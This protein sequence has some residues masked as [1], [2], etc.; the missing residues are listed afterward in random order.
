MFKP[1][2]HR[3]LCMYLW[4]PPVTGKTM[5]RIPLI[6]VF[7]DMVGNFT[8]DGKFSLAMLPDKLLAVLDEIDIWSDSDLALDLTKQ[9]LEGTEFTVARKNRD[10]GVVQPIHTFITTNTEPPTAVN[11][12]KHRSYHIE[13]VLSRIHP[14]ETRDLDTLDEGIARTVAKDEAPAWA[15]LCTQ[16]QPYITVPPE[17]LPPS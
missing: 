9:L 2:E 16:T 12:P 6:E 3:D 13:A 11:E 8:K 10:P 17:Y 7:G 5:F 15:I 1:K 4:G 14:Y